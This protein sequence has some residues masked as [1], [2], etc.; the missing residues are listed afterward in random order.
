MENVRRWQAADLGLVGC[1]QTGN[2]RRDNLG[3]AEEYDAGK[4][5]DGLLNFRR[6]TRNLLTAAGR[7]A[8]DGADRNLD[9]IARRLGAG[10]TA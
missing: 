1:F 4:F 6:N 5:R 10:M 2:G 8:G 3:Y 7:D 9:T